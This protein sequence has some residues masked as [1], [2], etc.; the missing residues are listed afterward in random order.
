LEKGAGYVAGYYVIAPMVA[1]GLTDNFSIAAGASF[2][3]A[4]NV[5]GAY[6][7]PKLGVMLGDYVALSIG[8]AAAQGLSQEDFDPTLIAAYG[9]ATFGRASSSLTLGTGYG[10]FRL[11]T[12]GTQE[13]TSFNGTLGFMVGGE[14]RVA[15]TISIVTENYFLQGL[16]N[17]SP[18]VSCGIRFFG[19]RFSLEGAFIN[20]LGPGG[21]TV[22]FPGFPFVGI[23][24]NF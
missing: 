2:L 10:I 4:V 18:V 14:V 8:G 22:R 3:A 11:Y 7:L 9:S 13:Q 1:Y 15:R 12:E 20:T 17:Y 5:A 6:F 19:E 21:F 23:I 24:Y 16:W